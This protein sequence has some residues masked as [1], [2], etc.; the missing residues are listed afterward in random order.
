MASPPQP[1]TDRARAETFTGVG[2]RRES[3]ARVR[4]GD[5]LARWCITAGGLLTI[6][7]VALVCGFLVWV[8]MPLFL[9]ADVENR[10]GLAIDTSSRR[11]LHQE[12]DPY[13]Q[14]LL[15]VD[16][17]GE[18]RLL[19]LGDGRPV[20]SVALLPDGG[21]LAAVTAHGGRIAFAAGD[22]AVQMARLGVDVIQVPLDRAPAAVRDLAPGQGMRHEQAWYERAQENYRRTTLRHDPQP[23]VRLPGGAV[24]ALDFAADDGTTT[25]A[26]VTAD[27]VLHLRAIERRVNPFTDELETDERGSDIAL[28]AL[29]VAGSM[30]PDRL[31]D[32]VFVAGA[33]DNVYLVWDDGRLLRLDTRDLEEPAL[34]ED[35]DLL[36]DGGRILAAEFQIGRNTLLVGDDRGRVRCWFRTKPPAARGADGSELDCVHRLQA[37]GAPVL[38]L[39]SSQRSR[40]FAIG[41]RDGTVAL[42]HATS[43]RLLTTVR[44]PIEDPVLG[45]ALGPKEDLLVARTADALHVYTVDPGHPEFTLAT[46]ITPIWYEGYA[47]PE[48]VWQ[49]TGASDDFEPKFGL[50]PLIFGTLKATLYCLLFGVPIALLAAIYTSEFLHPRRR[51]RIKPLV[52]SMASLP[53]VV[54]GFL[55]ALVFAPVVE[56]WL[57]TMLAAFVTVPLCWILGG[58]L[59]QALPSSLR[60]RC[61]ERRLWGIGLAIPVGLLLGDVAGRAAEGLMFGGDFQAWLAAPTTAPD[62]AGS[63]FG[64]WFVALLPFAALAAAVAVGRTRWLAARAA[65]GALRLGAGTALALALTVLGA[66]VITATGLDLRGSLVDTYVQRNALV[67]GFVM[68]FAVVPIIY[69]IAEDALVAVPEHLRAASLGAGATPWQTAVRIVLPTAMSGIFS[70]VMVGLGR[71]VGETMV[72]LMAAGNTPVLE[73]NPFNGFRTLSANIA[74]ELPEAVRDSTHYR[75]L[76]LAALV[77]FAMTFALNTV[78]ELVRQR[79]RRRAFQL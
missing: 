43:E 60:L 77:L 73:L 72:V 75:M 10:G 47:G 50:W 30:P 54:L 53:S 15:E 28:S 66:A 55:A 17:E 32:R 11:P 9:G 42:A 78:A 20:D 69:T 34:A 19:A 76:Y 37:T 14:V 45:L 59:V 3:S 79:F 2:R 16:A 56:A 51:A 26:A 23:A 12:L 61:E 25:V 58:Q 7:A 41:H 49:A 68:G 39:A 71:A 35:V 65:G 22:G 18:A 57:P 67:V 8:V 36:D 6:A 4:I 64:G 33:G 52:E 13:G 70:A 1:G 44:L 29:R 38:S 24:R 27:G 48:H 5:R 74:V 63:A 21:R 40:L 62:A 31:P 46:A